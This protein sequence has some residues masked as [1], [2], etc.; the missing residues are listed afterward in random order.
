MLAGKQA[1]HICRSLE[2]RPN[3][4][5]LRINSSPT[6]SFFLKQKQ[7]QSTMHI[8]SGILPALIFST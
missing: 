4:L 2:E 3:A 5:L 8:I 1:A 6:F 7:K